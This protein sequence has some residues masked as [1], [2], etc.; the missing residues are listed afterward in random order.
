[1]PYS[2]EGVGKSGREEGKLKH[3]GDMQGYKDT[4]LLF[5]NAWLKK[6]GK[7]EVQVEINQLDPSVMKAEALVVS[8]P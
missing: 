1:M 6:R 4:S 3:M 5:T 7:A 2:F 8:T